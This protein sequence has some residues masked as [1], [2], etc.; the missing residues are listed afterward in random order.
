MRIW[1]ETSVKFVKPIERIV[2]SGG[3]ARSVVYPGAYRA[4]EDT[5]MSQGV[6]A[7]AGSSAGSITAAMLAVGMTT[8]NFRRQ[9]LQTHFADLLGERTGKLINNSAGTTALSKSGKQLEQFIRNN[10]VVTVKRF[11][12]SI[13]LASYPS[14]TELFIKLE[15][16]SEPKFTFSDLATLRCYFPA[17]FKKLIIIAVKYPDGELK[18]FNSDQ[19]PDVEIAMACRASSSIPVLLEP[20]VI[21]NQQYVDGGVYD[22]IPTD[23]FDFDEQQQRFIPNT[24]PEQTLVFAFGEGFNNKKNPVFQALYGHRCVL[25][26]AGPGERM[27]RNMVLK[28]FGLEPTYKNTDRKEMGFQKLR[29]HYPRRTVELRVGNIRT[30]AFHMAEKLSRIMDSLGYLDT[31]K[32]ITHHD[33][34]GANF[35]GDQFYR[36]L[37]HNFQGI[38]RAIVLGANENPA[39]DAV[40]MEMAAL[41]YQLN[42]TLLDVPNEIKNKT[43]DRKMFNLIKD[44][45]ERAPDSAHAFALSRAVEYRNNTIKSEELSKEIYIESIKYSELVSMRAIARTKRYLFAKIIA[46]FSNF[47]VLGARFYVSRNSK[48]DLNNEN[49][50]FYDLDR[51]QVIDSHVIKLATSRK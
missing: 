23:Y 3:G 17:I 37:I 48:V 50:R 13:D 31:I 27:K 40:L 26:K 8:T 6:E 35:N 9:L 15:A 41:K 2:F 5:G 11:L 38:Y 21:D 22:N 24:K 30:T 29:D 43:I 25:Y 1:D 45:V 19:T 39:N 44:R 47:T 42:T 18:I 46:R 4:L 7:F 32:F 10:L 49:D 36:D 12:L 14:L 28:L 51:T 20:A 16:T 34:N 33:L